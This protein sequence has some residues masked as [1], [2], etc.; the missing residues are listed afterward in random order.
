[1][2]IFR[3]LLRNDFFPQLY[4]AAQRTISFINNEIIVGGQMFAR[5]FYKFVNIAAQKPDR[6]ITRIKPDIVLF[7]DFHQID[8]I[9][10]FPDN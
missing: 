8:W 5:L 2:R 3:R 1:M 9:F 10:N 7:S 4:L 6:G